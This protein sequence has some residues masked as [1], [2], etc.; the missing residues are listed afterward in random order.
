MKFNQ[1]VTV[2]IGSQNP[3]KVNC[4]KKAFSSCWPKIEFEYI[5]VTVPSGVKDQPLSDKE[6]ILGAKNR[7]KRALKIAKT[8]YGVGIE[9]GIIKMNGNFF[10]RAWVVVVNKMGVVGF[11]SSLSAPVPPKYM[12]L[13]K[14]GIEL[15]KVND[16]ITGRENTKH[17]NG[18][19]GFI[20]DNLVT[21][22]K[23]YTDAV[24]MA[25]ARFRKPE[26]FEDN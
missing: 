10:A 6:C 7:A 21:R 8:D 19:F 17:D 11:G 15:G 9:G 24:I 12:K 13:I 3:V 5:A 18:Y 2:A 26:I 1:M 23:G 16:M 22:E 4:T 14:K 25:L 20:S